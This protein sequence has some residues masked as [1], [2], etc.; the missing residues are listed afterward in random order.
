MRSPPSSPDLHP[1]EYLQPSRSSSPPGD[2]IEMAVR[3]M[4]MN[5]GSSSKLRLPPAAITDFAYAPSKS[6]YDFQRNPLR[7]LENQ[8]RRLTEEL[9]DLLDAQ[10]TALMK[11]ITANDSSRRP[12]SD[13]TSSLPSA[14]RLISRSQQHRKQPVVSL[15]KARMGIMS[16]MEELWTVK[17]RESNIY[18]QL[19]AERKKLL[20]TQ[21]SYSSKVSGLRAE[22]RKIDASPEAVEAE[23][24][25]AETAEV[26]SE[27]SRLRQ[28][29]VVLE[30]RYISMQASLKELDSIRESQAASYKL[31]L[32]TISK[33]TTSFLS[34]HSQTSPETAVQTWSLEADAYNE[35]MKS[36][37]L[38]KE[39]LEEGI[40]LWDRAL[41]VILRFEG[42]VREKLQ[43]TSLGARHEAS[44]HIRSEVE[45]VTKDLEEMLMTAR[46][47]G[48]KLL[49]AAIGTELQAFKEAG[50]FLTRNLVENE[51]AINNTDRTIKK[52]TG[53][54]VNASAD[55]KLVSRG[56]EEFLNYS[57]LDD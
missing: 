18:G 49:L 34:E 47:E 45:N 11:T 15:A 33:K 44:A 36:A 12:L 56:G 26:A 6:A 17:E 30:S 21:S 54:F 37:E 50:E 28:R 32:E 41:G 14:S 52:G 4:P 57:P 5:H 27:I 22:I 53:E 35:K 25:R 42:M 20:A 23:S 7:Q 48:W 1:P 8:T 13:S 2:S 16:A 55:S 31:S 19:T 29:L 9:Q 46:Q 39:A 43:S 38:E 3:N 40:Q 24:L 10:S 51:P